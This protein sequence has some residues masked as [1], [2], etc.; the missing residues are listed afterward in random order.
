MKNYFDYPLAIS[1]L[2]LTAFGLVMI[3]DASVVLASRDFHDPLF[4]LKNQLVWVLGGL[5]MGF[6]TSQIDFHF[7]QKTAKI[8]F[9]ATLAC[10]LIVLIPG[11]SQETY[12]A[13]RRLNLPI[14][15]P[16]VGIIGFQPSELAKFTLIAYLASFLTKSLENLKKSKNWRRDL[17]NK[18][19]T[20]FLPFG[21]ILGIPIILIYPE[22]DLGTSIVLSLSAVSMFI[23]FGSSLWEGLTVI[24]S[25]VVLGLLF[26]FSS[27]YRRTRFLSFLNPSASI[28]VEGYHLNQAL[29]AVGSGGLLG[30]GLGASRQK[31]LYLPEVMTDSIIAVVGEELGLLGTVIVLV[32][33]AII[34]Y[35]GTEIVKKTKDPFG[36]L[37]AFGIV[38]VLAIQTFLN[39][40]SMLGLTPLTGVPLPFVSYG[41]SNI[42][43]LLFSIGVL[44]NISKGE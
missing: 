16:V 30:L 12:G 14:N 26:I 29:I 11:I 1:C 42:L 32:L 3:Y 9:I 5:V 20:R 44:L 36:C 18:F 2:L 19:F 41:G 13:K 8:W 25:G 31:F 38:A 4:F 24:I 6:L 33:L 34:I 28:Q 10:L 43:I 35:R 7:W 27:D 23:F 37:L 17:L 39:L 15:F 40:G 21:I 22:P